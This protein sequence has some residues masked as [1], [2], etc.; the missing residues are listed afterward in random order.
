MGT[1]RYY[2]CPE[3]IISLDDLPHGWG[4]LWVNARGHVKLMAGHVCCLVD[5]FHNHPLVWCWTHEVNE[6]L[7]RDMMAHLLSRIGDPE[8]E[9]EVNRRIRDADG[10][11][12]R[13]VK[14]VNDLQEEARKGSMR[15]LGKW[16]AEQNAAEAIDLL[17]VVIAGATIDDT[18][19]QQLLNYRSSLI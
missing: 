17:A 18:K 8:E 6:Q 11:V 19:L 10:E 3:G 16:V 1:W 5:H 7:E 15:A 14:R 13:L 9:E 2:M 12:S 4:L